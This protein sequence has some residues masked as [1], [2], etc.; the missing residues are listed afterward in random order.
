MVA[1]FCGIAETNK[2]RSNK[3]FLGSIHVW[4]ELTLW[5]V[6]VNFVGH[7]AG[8]FREEIPRPKLFDHSDQLLAHRE[9]RGVDFTGVANVKVD[10]G[11]QGLDVAKSRGMRVLIPLRQE[12]LDVSIDY[13]LKITSSAGDC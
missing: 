3:V 1:R 9:L 6:D 4:L 13:T 8:A 10:L 2:K 12:V 5:S 11:F 7:G